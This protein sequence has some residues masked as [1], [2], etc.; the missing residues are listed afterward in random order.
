MQGD[1][2]A[3]TGNLQ[4]YVL[5]DDDKYIDV[6]VDYF[7]DES[8]IIRYSQN[9]GNINTRGRALIDVCTGNNLRILNGR[10]TGDL[11]GKKT[12]YKYNGSSV[13][14]YIISDKNILPKVQFLK[15]N[16]LLPDISDHCQ[17]SYCLKVNNLTAK[18]DQIKILKHKHKT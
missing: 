11:S 3:R 14:D 2:N 6:P 18:G 15:V 5:F 12:C 7:I 17:I 13:V 16:P 10:I 4:E 8:E 1:F 9:E